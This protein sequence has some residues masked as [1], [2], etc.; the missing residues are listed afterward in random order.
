MWSVA[1]TRRRRRLGSGGGQEG[2]RGPR[3]GGSEDVESRRAR[4][5]Q[6]RDVLPSNW[7]RSP[8]P[9]KPVLS[10]TSFR[11]SGAGRTIFTFNH[12]T[13]LAPVDRY[14]APQRPRCTPRG[15]KNYA[16]NAPVEKNPHER[17]TGKT[18][19]PRCDTVLF[20]N[21]PRAS[22]ELHSLKN[23]TALSTPE[24]GTGDLARPRVLPVSRSTA[25]RVPSIE[26]RSVE[27]KIVVVVLVVIVVVVVLVPR[28]DKEEHRR[29]TSPRSLARTRSVH[30]RS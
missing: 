26:I 22:P 30:R 15:T 12:G 7:T 11:M 3:V 14:N 9:V 2:P 8:L 4:L 10:A 21:S 17:S 6:T 23:S 18:L 1:G 25:R 5:G 16:R 13:H 27:V 24:T 29:A 19:G 28:A 20:T